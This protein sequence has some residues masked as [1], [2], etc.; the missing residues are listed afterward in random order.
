MRK[1]EYCGHE[2]TDDLTRCSGCGTEFLVPTAELPNYEPSPLDLRRRWLIACGIYPEGFALKSP[3]FGLL[4]VSAPVMGFVFARVFV[5]VWDPGGPGA[6]GALGNFLYVTGFMFL[7]FLFGIG[8][9]VAALLRGERRRALS[10]VGLV[11]NL[12]PILA[13]LLGCL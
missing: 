4:S 10:F 7:A 2:N 6:D 9:A 8:L 1:C 12:V 11:V 5:A 13:F 3:T